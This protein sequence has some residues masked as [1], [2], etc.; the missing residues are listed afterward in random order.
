MTDNLILEAINIYESLSHEF[1]VRDEL[2]N[3]HR[4][5]NATGTLTWSRWQQFRSVDVGS[6]LPYFRR[7]E[8]VYRR[9]RVQDA[10]RNS[11][12]ALVSKDMLAERLQMPLLY[13]MANRLIMRKW[14]L[15][16]PR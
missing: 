6:C 5:I 15:T 3:L 16:D 14:K 1:D 9:I 4:A 10:V 8:E 7:A 2:I 11:S 12:R 13:S